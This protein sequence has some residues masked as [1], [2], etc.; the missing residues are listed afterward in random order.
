[1]TNDA[2]F[3][4]HNVQSVYYNRY[5]IVSPPLLCTVSR[6]L[7]NKNVRNIVYIKHKSAGNSSVVWLKFKQTEEKTGV[8]NNLEDKYTSFR[9]RCTM[10]HI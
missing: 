4:V 8:G 2:S 7:C 3:A 1:M 9:P 6:R 10:R 5:Y